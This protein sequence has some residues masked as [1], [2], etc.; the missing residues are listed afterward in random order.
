MSD[1]QRQLL[2]ATIVFGVLALGGAAYYYYGFAKDEIE[3]NRKKVEVLEKE[4]KE[5]E[6]NIK[7]YDEF[8]ETRPQVERLV[9]A[10][11]DASTRLPSDNDDRRYVEK[12]RDFIAKT[13]VEMTALEK[14]KQQPYPDWIEYPQLISGTT[15][16]SDFVQFLSLAEQNADYFMRVKDFDISNDEKSNNPTVHPFTLTLSSFVFKD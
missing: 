15:R 14:Q 16:Y 5:I 6:K 9:N 4:I 11:A 12:M 13:G 8:L 1:T 10:I 7:R 3:A 2:I